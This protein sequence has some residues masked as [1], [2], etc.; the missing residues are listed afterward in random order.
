MDRPTRMEII[1]YV[2]TA[3]ARRGPVTTKGI[4][5]RARGAGAPAAV[6]ATLEQLPDRRFS[7]IRQLWEEL[8]GVPIGAHT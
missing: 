2:G 6:I 3:F 4:L 1:D 5:R 7:N 8:P